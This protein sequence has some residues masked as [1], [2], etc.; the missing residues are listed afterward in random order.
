MQDLREVCDRYGLYL[1]MDGARLGYGLVA[2]DNDLWLPDIARLCDAF[3]FGGTKIGALFGEA[4]VIT[5]P[6]IKLT[7]GYIKNRGALLAKGWLLGVQ[8]DTLFTD[9]LYLKISKNAVDKAMRLRAALEA[10]GYPVY[11]ESPTNQQFVVVENR[12]MLELKKN[13]G[14]NFN[15]AIGK[16]HSVIRFATSWA[17]TDEQI[18]ELIKLL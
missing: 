14:F 12:K 8:F 17:T 1:Y 5:N 15:E 16:D 4:V 11:L 9:D 13:I 2:K 18:D 6:E 7:L 10:K 3:Y